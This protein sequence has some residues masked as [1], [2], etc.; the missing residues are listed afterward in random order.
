MQN[1]P[2]YA[3]VVEFA[4]GLVAELNRR[5]KELDEMPEYDIAAEHAHRHFIFGNVSYKL[6][7]VY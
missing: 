1:V 7:A 2:F 3:E 4:K 5:R 6:V